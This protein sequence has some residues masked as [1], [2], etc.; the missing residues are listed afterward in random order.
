MRLIAKNSDRRTDRYVA[1]IVAS[2]DPHLGADH[3]V[4]HPGA[5]PKI[6]EKTAFSRQSIPREYV[7]IRPAYCLQRRGLRP[8]AFACD[9]STDERGRHSHGKTRLKSSSR[10]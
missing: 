5:G 6:G 7:M 8:A 4:V 3:D 2:K 9:E 10:N 1:F